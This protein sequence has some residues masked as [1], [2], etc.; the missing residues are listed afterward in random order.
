MCNKIIDGVLLDAILRWFFCSIKGS[1]IV[2]S[3]CDTHDMDM[4]YG[5]E[6][7]W[8]G[9]FS[10]SFGEKKLEKWVKEMQE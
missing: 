10:D 9:L 6:S 8:Y 5:C 2:K 3:M 7:T 4:C 1:L